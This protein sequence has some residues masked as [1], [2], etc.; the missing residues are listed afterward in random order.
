MEPDLSALSDILK[1]HPADESSL[2]MVL[3]DIQAQYN[4]LPVEALRRTARALKLPDSRV[5][6]VA[7]FYRAFSLKPR[8]RC[9]VKVCKGTACHVRG[10]P[11]IEEE[12]ERTLRVKS[13]ETTADGEYT[14]ETVNCVGACGMAPVVLVGEQYHAEVKPHRVKRILGAAKGAGE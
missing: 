3:Q 2:V 4:Y 13:G 12:L 11:L 10:A 14:L 1:R 8:G 5:F 6:G 7:T 9:I